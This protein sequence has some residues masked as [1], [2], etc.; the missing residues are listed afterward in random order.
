MSGLLSM[1]PFDLTARA[2]IRDA[3]MRLYAE[4]GA[5]RATTIRAV[6]AEAG[7]TAGLVSHHFGTKQALRDACDA[8]VIDYLRGVV[9]EAVDHRKL[10]DPA[11]LDSTFQRGL[12]VMRYLSR[13]LADGSPT[14]TVLFDDIVALTE[15]YLIDHPAQHS[16]ER[17][18]DTRSQAAVMVAM[19]L[20]MWVLSDHLV[21][22][23]GADSM[24]SQ[25]M[26]RIG[27]AL[28]D[29]LSAEFARP[30]LL[31]LARS[32]LEALQQSDTEQD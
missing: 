18:N 2:R 32:G 21:R 15:Q 9:A 14:A 4:H 22:A 24:N 20:G 12:V 28:G 25:T 5:G 23:L 8:Y 7:V 10:A 6:A 29:V 19:R 27:A 30:D 31:D 1:R 11:Y 16:P 26:S 3:A 17:T 13:A